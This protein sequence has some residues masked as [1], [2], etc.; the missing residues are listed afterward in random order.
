M[1]KKPNK[2]K[3]AA[4][5]ARAAKANVPAQPAPIWGSPPPDFSQSDFALDGAMG[6]EPPGFG[7]TEDGNSARRPRTLEEEIDPVLRGDFSTPLQPVNPGK[8]FSRALHTT[9]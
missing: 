7:F 6:M 1:P 3:A 8:Y 5:L 4:A 2:K 9:H